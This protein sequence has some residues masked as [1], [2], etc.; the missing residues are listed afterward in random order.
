MNL[1]V[2]SIHNSNIQPF[3]KK[4]GFVYDFLEAMRMAL[5]PKRAIRCTVRGKISS[6]VYQFI[7]IFHADSA[8]QVNLPSFVYHEF[9]EEKKDLENRLI[10][11][12]SDYNLIN[13]N[14]SKSDL[15]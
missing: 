9:I 10:I 2:Q 12:L 5:I 3:M 8:T 13:Y 15:I 4:R 6:L 1:L 14:N 11:I 7:C